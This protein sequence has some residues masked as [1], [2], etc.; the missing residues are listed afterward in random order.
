MCRSTP[1]LVLPCLAWAL[2]AA[3]LEAQQSRPADTKA[4]AKAREFVAEADRTAGPGSVRVANARRSL[5]TALDMAG[6]YDEALAEQQAA[7]RILEHNP[8]AT[9]NQRAGAY[10]EH[11]VQL[12]GLQRLNEALGFVDKSIETREP[13]DDFPDRRLAKILYIRA[14]ILAELGRLEDAE[15]SFRKSIAVV[16]DPSTGDPTAL[17]L[18]LQGLGTALTMSGRFAEARVALT[19]AAEIAR[20]D[21]SVDQV[22]RAMGEGFLGFLEDSLGRSGEARAHFERQLAA[23]EAAGDTG[24][25]RFVLALGNLAHVLIQSGDHDLAQRTFGRAIEA[26]ESRPDQRS[27]GYILERAASLALSRG[28]AAQSD[29]LAS[30]AV[31]FHRPR[32]QQNPAKLGHALT[33]LAL[34]KQAAG[35]SADALPIIEEAVAIEQA[36]LGRHLSVAR[37]LDT[38]GRVL[39]ALGRPVESRDAFRDSFATTRTWLEWATNALS[40]S[41]RFAS[42]GRV[43]SLADA[44]L[45]SELAGRTDAVAIADGVLAWQGQILRSLYAERAWL[46]AHADPEA[47]LM[48]SRLAR[49]A[50][51]L[52]P[53]RLL[54]GQRM[55]RR[56]AAS[57]LVA[58]RERL[59]RALAARASER[60][61]PGANS[62]TIT[63]AL[64]AGEALVD[65]FVWER[66]DAAAP[67]IRSARGERLLA[68][69]LRRGA[70]PAILDLGPLAPIRDAASAHVTTV[71]ELATPDPRAEPFA[72]AAGAAARRALWEPIVPALAGARRV[73]IVTD[74][75]LAAVPFDT[76]P[77]DSPGRY[78]IEDV[79]IVYLPVAAER[80]ARASAPLGTGALVVGAVDFGTARAAADPVMQD[81]QSSLGLPVSALPKSGDEMSAV[82]AAWSRAGFEPAS[83]QTLSAAAAT[84]AAVKKSV[85]G[86]RLVHFATHG[87]Y[88]PERRT[89]AG[90]PESRVTFRPRTAIEGFLP[91]T[92][93]AVALAGVN[94]AGGAGADDGLLTA[95]EVAWLDLGGCDLVTLSCCDSGLGAARSGEGLIGLRRAFRLAGARATV[96][97]LW[98]VGDEDAAALMA[99]FYDRL[100]AGRLGKAKALR[101]ARLSILERNRARHGGQGLPGS[102]GAFVLEGAWE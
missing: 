56:A 4:V 68:V 21:G 67:L 6:R 42:L 77:G 60:G 12:Y 75:F 64:A 20:E 95:A 49:I 89:I 44:W 36:A 91:G 32:A 17:V 90:L 23:Y 39:A 38:K 92:R 46:R 62:A 80:A 52:A 78:L 54:P 86:R 19:E 70:P 81:V 28:D 30:R 24:S 58:E 73:F 79:E 8:D 2:V 97:T 33:T 98:R 10:G 27:F 47:V 34:A 3:S 48:A 63:E 76:L 55:A 7:L 57:E 13:G 84:E 29:A 1:S 9:P 16:R 22:V 96:T 5:S 72:A 101:E 74:S 88:A 99:A 94:A 51:E 31:A 40:E 50:D 43:R 82:T 26:C 83:I 100:L 37:A 15:A 61:A 14:S 41:E 85:A 66:V 35:R 45:S 59:E 71:A 93:A 87:L 25:E 102:W 11:A 53:D 65:Y 18:G 69:V